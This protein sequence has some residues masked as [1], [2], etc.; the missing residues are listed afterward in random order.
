MGLRVEGL[1]FE[2]VGVLQVLGTLLRT[3]GPGVS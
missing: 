1:G 2:G 3:G